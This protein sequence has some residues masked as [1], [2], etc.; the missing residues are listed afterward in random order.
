L[1]YLLDKFEELKSLSIS[2]SSEED[3]PTL[4]ESIQFDEISTSSDIQ[5]KK[6]IQLK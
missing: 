5:Y 4:E 6:G 2:C 1:H 3:I